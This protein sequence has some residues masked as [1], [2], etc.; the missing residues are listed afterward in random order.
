MTADDA[1]YLSKTTD[2]FSSI[3]GI[4]K[5]FYNALVMEVFLK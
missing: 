4:N 2:G 3:F 1:I 5:A